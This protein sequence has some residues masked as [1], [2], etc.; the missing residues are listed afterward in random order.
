[1][2]RPTALEWAQ[3]TYPIREDWSWYYLLEWAKDTP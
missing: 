2:I 1:M 3:I